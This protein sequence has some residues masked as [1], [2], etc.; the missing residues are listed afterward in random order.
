[1]AAYCFFD[2]RE[3]LDPAKM[4]DY[5]RNVL[6]TVEQYGGRYVVMGGTCDV[7]EGQ[8]KPNFPVIIRF[9]D[10]SS[11]GYRRYGGQAD[12]QIYASDNA[13][14]NALGRFWIRLMSVL[15]YVY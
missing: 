4:E 11:R 13:L 14:L 2:I 5:R 6:A 8:W 9:D 10:D 1:M 15:T 3:V 7:I 12:V